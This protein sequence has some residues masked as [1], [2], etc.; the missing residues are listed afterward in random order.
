MASAKLKSD[1]TLPDATLPDATHSN[2]AAPPRIRLTPRDAGRDMSLQDFTHAVGQ[3]GWRYE[4][5]DGRIEVFPNPEVPH[6]MVLEWVREQLRVYRDAHREVINYV[7]G[8]SRVFIPSRREVT[9]PQPDLAAFRDF[10]TRW[11]RKMRRWQDVQPI[12]VVE[13]LS[14]GYHRKDLVRNVALYRESPSVKEYWVFDPRDGG[15]HPTLRVYR[16][17]GNRSWQRPIDV[18]FAGSYTTALL[19]GFTLVVDPNA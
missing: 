11:P 18:P 17:R 6:D 1:A 16:K 4:L 9:C 15:D 5:I 8:G 13:V 3:N 10:P 14:E 7:T 12:L 19:P 2:G